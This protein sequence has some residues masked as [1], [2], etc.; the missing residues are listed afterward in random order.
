[1][2]ERGGIDDVLVTA[3]NLDLVSRGGIPDARDVVMSGRAAQRRDDAR[4]IRAEGRGIEVSQFGVLV[5]AQYLDL[6]SCGGIPD[7]RR[8]FREPNFAR[9]RD[10]AF[11]VRAKGR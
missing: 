1:R 4:A 9:R 8:I 3:Q 10:D 2:T 11:P 7:A 6:V 5:S